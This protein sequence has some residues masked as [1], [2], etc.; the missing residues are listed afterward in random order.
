[1]M[2]HAEDRENRRPFHKP[3]GNLRTDGY[4]LLAAL[5]REA[6]SK[7]MKR[8]LSTLCWDDSLP[9][10]LCLTLSDLKRT[11]TDLS[12]EAIEHEF[13]R[14]FVGLGSGELVPY[15]SWY[16]K[17]TIQSAPLAAIR[18]DLKR[19]GLIRQSRAF[20]SE[21]HVSALCEIMALLSSEEN[22]VFYSEQAHF[23][24]CHLDTWMPKFFSDLVMAENC[25][26]YRTVGSFGGRF[27]EEER[28]YLNSV[29]SGQP[30]AM[31]FNTQPVPARTG[32]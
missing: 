17:K 27:L 6:P 26:F 12:L 29:L 30:D 19:F 8:L 1:M 21:D 4:V 23:F 15:G 3:H 7:N 31:Q 20:E 32:Q 16:L 14:L 25:P 9:R 18:T 24:R 13:D 11:G 5:L 10:N 28:S 22:A 2:K